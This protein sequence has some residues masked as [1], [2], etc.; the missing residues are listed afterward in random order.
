MLESLGRGR[1]RG[2]STMLAGLTALAMV[3]IG[4][5]TAGADA[6]PTSAKPAAAKMKAKTI[7]NDLV[8][9]APAKVR[10]TY[11]NPDNGRTG[12]VKAKFVPEN[13]VAQDGAVAVEGMLVGHFTGKLSKGTPRH[14]SE[15]V[16][17]A[18][19]QGGGAS[20]AGF[21][22]AAHVQNVA[23]C[24]ILNLVLGP[25]HLDLL[26]LVIDLNQVVLNIVAQSGAGN[27]LGNLLCAVAGLLDGGPLGGLL[28]GV[29]DAL[30]GLLGGL[31]DLQAILDQLGGLLGGAG[32]AS[33]TV[34]AA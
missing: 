4:L 13:F 8:Q 11:T 2:A 1:L 17:M 21:Q 19:Q 10:G 29:I 28:G 33:Q 18:V 27:L 3:L 23:T 14:F 22:S 26:G 34:A 31:L 9:I 32:A 12:K 6:A 24:D 25:L 30:N 20:P 15:P 5:S 16:T 7:S